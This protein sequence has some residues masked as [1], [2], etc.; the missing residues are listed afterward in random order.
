ML[1]WTY[2]Q[3][4]DKA[5]VFLTCGSRLFSPNYIPTDER[6]MSDK[7]A[8]RLSRASDGMLVR[9][10]DEIF[11]EETNMVIVRKHDVFFSPPTQRAQTNFFISVFVDEGRDNQ[12]QIG[13]QIESSKD[14]FA[15]TLQLCP[16]STQRPPCFARNSITQTSGF[17]L[18]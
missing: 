17:R 12:G 11:C 18:P 4:S 2:T 15:L 13:V 3:M 5:I 10:D 16:T 9:D 1:T 7:L 14:K 8:I 6:K